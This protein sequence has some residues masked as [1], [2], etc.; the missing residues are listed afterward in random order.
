MT[1]VDRTAPGR[2]ATR[3]LA[4]LAVLVGLLAMHGLTSTHHAAAATT[5]AQH[6]AA[7]AETSP[8]HQ[9]GAPA[10]PQD[11][12]PLAAPDGPGCGDDCSDL[13]VLCLAVLAGA[14]IALLLAR[15]R[16]APL[17]PAPDGDAAAARAPPVRHARGPDP[18]RELCV[19]RT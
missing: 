19:S 8:R 16:H 2:A 1:S 11:A 14:V 15:R 7:P 10:V 13:G 6:D 5:L 17:P 12:Y 9:H 4:M 3:L 18:V